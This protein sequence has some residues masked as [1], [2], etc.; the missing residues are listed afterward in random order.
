MQQLP[1]IENNDPCEKF[2][3]QIEHLIMARGIY[4]EKMED[5][6]KLNVVPYQYQHNLYHKE[7]E[8]DPKM[9]EYEK[10]LSHRVYLLHYNDLNFE[11]II[12]L[13]V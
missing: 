7:K 5:T 4:L 13:D 9:T 2:F 6:D 8:A 1:K 10:L 11:E 12:I 3:V